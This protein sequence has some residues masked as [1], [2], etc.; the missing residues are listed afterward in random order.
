M[1][2]DQ[3]AA[4]GRP[5]NIS[6]IITAS[7][8]TLELCQQRS[9]GAEKHK[10]HCWAFS[11]DH[12]RTIQG[13]ITEFLRYFCWCR[14]NR[15]S[16]IQTR[17]SS[18]RRAAPSLAGRASS[19]STAAER[20]QA[21][22]HYIR[23]NVTG[24]V[25]NLFL[26]PCLWHFHNNS[27]SARMAAEP[28]TLTNGSRFRAQLATAVTFYRSTHA[29]LQTKTRWHLRKVLLSDC[30]L[31]CCFSS[32]RHVRTAPNP[33]SPPSELKPSK[34]CCISHALK[35]LRQEALLGHIGP[36]RLFT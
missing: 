20:E 22:A 11:R 16:S 14:T 23:P 12:I 1:A 26:A 19:F 21:S 13:V 4:M 18:K 7:R 3:V 25:I 17:E 35:N 29:V 10:W 30:W 36:F 34:A 5:L 32:G 28:V 31:P 33:S 6:I 27:N 2:N 15:S 9:D 24:L 8:L